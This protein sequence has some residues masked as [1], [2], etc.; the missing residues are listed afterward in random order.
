MKQTEQDR[1]QDQALLPSPMTDDAAASTGVAALD[2]ALDG[3]YWGD[4]VVWESEAAAACEPF[5]GALAAHRA[6][7][8]FAGYV[9][10]D[11]SPEEVAAAY[12]GFEVLDARAGRGIGRPAPLLQAIYERCDRAERGLLLFDPLDAMA[13]RWGTDT[14][15]AFFVRCCPHLLEVGA[16]A[17]WTVGLGPELAPLRRE[18]SEV[19]QCVLALGEDRLRIAKAD[20]RAPGVEGSVFRCRVAGGRPV[21]E[22]APAAAR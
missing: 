15:R 13:R 20:A 21:L 12:P 5:Y 14:A 2:A 1:H 7:Y 11:R 17:Y 9:A 3:L 22:A 19:T 8:D 18:I 16:I 10:I 6:A 4:N